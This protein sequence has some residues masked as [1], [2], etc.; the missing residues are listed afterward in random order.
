MENRQQEILCG[1]I[2]EYIRTG[3]PVSSAVLARLLKMK[4]SSATIRSEYRRLNEEGL[5]EQPY[6]SAGRIPTDKGYRYYV[7]QLDTGD[8]EYIE[9][10]WIE[11]QYEGMVRQFGYG[12]FALAALLS[13]VSNVLAL[14]SQLPAGRFTQ[15]GL[16]QLLNAA[17]EKLHVIEEISNWL[18]NW[19]QFMPALAALGEQQ[20]EVYIGE[21]NPFFE[22]L[23]TSIMVRQIKHKD[24]PGIIIMLFGPKR[25]DYERNIS[26]MDEVANLPIK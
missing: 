1:L 5:I 9:R 10:R 26:L 23:Y 6:T 18:D 14:T 24:H 2:D 21:E 12:E 3:V 11:H 17:D 7:D 15:C 13:R 25:M 8:Q 19:Q 4:L 22:S 20:T 16:T